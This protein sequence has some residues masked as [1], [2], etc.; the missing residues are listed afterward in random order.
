[1]KREVRSRMFVPGNRSF[2]SKDLGFVGNGGYG[3]G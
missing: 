3:M 2:V 1:M